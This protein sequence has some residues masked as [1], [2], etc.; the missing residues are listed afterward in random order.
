MRPNRGPGPQ[1]Q[2]VHM[3]M[4]KGLF[5]IAGMTLLMLILFASAAST[6]TQVSKSDVLKSQWN[7][8]ICIAIMVLQM[9]SVGIG[10]LLI[11]WAGLKYMSSDNAED[12]EDARNIIVRVLSII[13]V[14]A[15]AVQVVNYL[16]SG[17]SIGRFDMG[18]CSDL[19]PTTTKPVPTSSPTTSGTT[20]TTGGNGTTTSSTSSTTSSTTTTIPKTCTDPSNPYGIYGSQNV[21]QKVEENKNCKLDFGTMDGGPPNGMPDIDDMLGAGFARCCCDNGYPNCC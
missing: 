3:K 10:A 12:R 18:S 17:S 6:T 14:I 20:T 13:V 11:I 8:T 19:F 4:R 1:L 9:V 15:L 21:C 7:R 16:I 5:I 2:N